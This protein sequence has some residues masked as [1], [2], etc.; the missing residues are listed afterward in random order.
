[1]TANYPTTP[2]FKAAGTS[3]QAAGAVKHKAKVIR[4]KCLRML[5]ERGDF[6][7]QEMA[8]LL[9]EHLGDVAPRLSELRKENVIFNSGLTRPNA[10]G[11]AAMVYTLNAQSKLL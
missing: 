3:E 1:M 9:D 5:R 8:D 2:G 10:R 4:E 11:N 6:T 7:A